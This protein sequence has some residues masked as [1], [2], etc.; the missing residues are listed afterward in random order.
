MI[1]RRAR[2]SLVVL[3]AALGV[4]LLTPATARAHAKLE[5]SDPSDG[6]TLDAS[7][8]VVSLA[9]TEPPELSLSS[10]EVLDSTGRSFSGG[11]VRIA[12]GD[13]LRLLRNVTSLP[14]GVYTVAW[15]VVSKADGHA[16]AGAFAFGVRVPP[17]EVPPPATVP[18]PMSPPLSPLEVGGRLLLIAG[19]VALLG[20]VVG[21]AAFAGLP[22]R[23]RTLG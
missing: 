20:A 8:R 23:V 7:P 3:V 6:A 1:P 15:R 11:P 19:L 18:A 2:W 21:L 12:Q 10:I 4:V 14:D 22:R 16:T 13:P 5:S 9:F 17:P